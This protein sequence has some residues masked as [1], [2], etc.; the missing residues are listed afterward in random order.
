M[1]EIFAIASSLWKRLLGVRVVYFLTLCAIS[2]IG[3]TNM[4]DILMIGEAKA[5]M[6]DTAM[7][8]TTVAA[9]LTVISLA[10]DIPKELQ[11]GIAS[12]LLSK[13][14]GRTHYLIGKLV[15]ISWVGIFITTLIS[16]GFLIIFSISHGPPTA[17]IV[18]GLLLI[19]FSV[20]PMAAIVL[21]FSSFLNEA[22][23]ATISTVTIW[24]GFSLAFLNGYTI[25]DLSIFNMGAEAFYGYEISNFFVVK[26]AF[27]AILTAISLVCATSIIFNK[28]D[29]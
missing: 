29:L 11:S 27:S 3:I 25:F 10:F 14:L 22:V 17:S 9:I 13:P 24:M 21:F 18:K 5:L 8:L 7:M 4:Y 15:G 2:L 16:I 6:V 12:V 26:A 28:R 19:I 1:D 20:I 23:A